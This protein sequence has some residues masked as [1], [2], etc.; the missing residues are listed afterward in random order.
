M[1]E[2]REATKK[3]MDKFLTENLGTCWDPNQLLRYSGWLDRFGLLVI[4]IVV[5]SIT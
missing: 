3:I 5:M 1:G 2:Y 4:G